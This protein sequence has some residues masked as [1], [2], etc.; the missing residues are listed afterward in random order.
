MKVLQDKDIWDNISERYLVAGDSGDVRLKEQP[1]CEFLSHYRIAHLGVMETGHPYELTRVKQN[2]SCIVA[3]LEGEGQVLVDNEWIHLP[4]GKACLLPPFVDNSIKTISDNWR[5][6]WVKYIEAE[7]VNCVAT[8]LSPVLADFDARPLSHACMGLYHTNLTKNTSTAS[9]WVELIHKQVLLFAA[10][11]IEDKRIWRLWIQVEKNLAHPWT[12]KEMA[13]ITNMSAEHLRRLCQK[14]FGRSPKEQ[15]CFLRMR[16][17][18]YLLS[19]SKMKVETIAHQIGYQDA[20]HFSNTF[21]K[22]TGYR[23]SEVR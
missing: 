4:K 19:V 12:L 6:T 1:F 18:R 9:L 7:D 8:S 5:F 11:N 13:N 23:P 3:T 16:Q 2:G 22:I 21:K 15:L 17:A 20:F 14:Q 10:P